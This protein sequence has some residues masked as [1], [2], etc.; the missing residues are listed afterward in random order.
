MKTYTSKHIVL[1]V[2]KVIDQATKKIDVIAA[3]FRRDVLLDFCTKHELEFM[4]GNGRWSFY[5]RNDDT[6]SSISDVD[7][8][9][10]WAFSETALSDEERDAAIVRLHEDFDVIAEILN[11]EIDS[12][13]CL[14][15][16]VADVKSSD[17]K[18][19]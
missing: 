16:R 11:T 5:A 14:G 3:N 19:S 17:W 6:I 9:S 7:A 10:Q 4:S 8:L 2:E 18:K 13:D 1:A 15:F 12:V